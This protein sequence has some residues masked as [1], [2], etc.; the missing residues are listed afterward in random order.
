ME[1]IS[2]KRKRSSEEKARDRV[3]R[4][5]QA[6]QE[7]R[8][9][10]KRYVKELEETNQT[11]L[12]NN[13]L[14]VSTVS[15]LQEQNRLLSE[16]L[17]S[18]LSLLNQSPSPVLLPTLVDPVNTPFTPIVNS[19]SQKMET[20]ISPE[21]LFSFELSEKSP[22][23]TLDK[24][25]FDIK[26]SSTS[27]LTIEQLFN[28][29]QNDLYSQEQPLRDS[30]DPAVVKS[31][32]QIESPQ[33]L[34]STF[35]VGGGFSLYTKPTVYAFSNEKAQ[36]DM[37][38]ADT[39]IATYAW[40][41]GGQKDTTWKDKVTNGNGNGSITV[42]LWAKSVP[43][44]KRG[45]PGKNGFSSNYFAF[46]LYNNYALS[47]TTTGFNGSV[48]Q[49]CTSSNG[50]ILAP[51][52]ETI[53][54]D[55]NW[56]HYSATYDS[57]SGVKT[58][59][60][61]GEIY[62]TTNCTTSGGALNIDGGNLVLGNAMNSGSFE[63]WLDEVRIWSVARTQQQIKDNMH[64]ALIPSNEPD[65]VSY[66]PLDNPDPSKHVFFDKKGGFD[67]SLGVS[68]DASDTQSKYRER[69]API[70]DIS[71][72]PV[73][74]SFVGVKI[75]RGIPATFHL[76]GQNCKGSDIA[77]SATISSL[78]ATIPG[79][80]I[81]NDTVKLSVNSTVFLCDTLTI[82][83]ENSG[84]SKKDYYQGTFSIT[85]VQGV[86]SGYFQIEAAMVPKTAPGPSGNALYCNGNYDYLFAP[87]WNAAKLGINGKFTV[88]T[89]IYHLS[90][91]V[92]GVLFSFGNQEVSFQNSW[93]RGLSGNLNYANSYFCNGRYSIWVPNG[94]NPTLI[95][96]SNWDQ[97]SNNGSFTVDAFNK[98]GVWYHVAMVEDGD[99]LSL[100]IDGDLASKVPSFGG[101]NTNFS[102]IS[103]LW[104][105]HW[106]FWGENMHD[107]KGFI[108]EFRIYNT[109]I[110][111]EEIRDKMYRSIELPAQEPHLVTFYNFD[112]IYTV[113]GEGND[114]I[115]LTPDSSAFHNDIQ[116]SACVPNSP[117]FC[118]TAAGDNCN[119]VQFPSVPCYVTPGIQ[120]VLKTSN[121]QIVLS[122]APIGGYHSNKTF[123]TYSKD[124]NITITLYGAITTFDPS[125]FAIIDLTN[126]NSQIGV[127]RDSSGNKLVNGSHVAF[128]RVSSTTTVIFS[129]TY[130]QAGY[131][132]NQFSYAI[133]NGLYTSEYTEIS[134]D[135]Y[136]P[137]TQYFDTTLNVCSQCPHGTISLDSNLNS[138]CTPLSNPY[139]LVLQVIG[140]VCILV[141]ILILGGLFVTRNGKIVRKSDITLTTIII[142][143]CI[144]LHV[145]T[146]LKTFVANTVSCVLNPFILVQSLVLIVA[147]NLVK[148]YR[149]YDIFFV[150]CFHVGKETP[151][152]RIYAMIV[153]A[154]LI[155]VAIFAAWIK[156]A[157][158]TPVL[159]LS[160]TTHYIGCFSASHNSFNYDTIF[161]SVLSTYVFI[162]TFSSLYFC[163]SLK[164]TAPA[165]IDFS[166]T[167]RTIIQAIFVF[168]FIVLAQIYVGNPFT[169]D[170]IVGVVL[171]AFT[172]NVS[173]TTVGKIIYKQ[174]IEKS[175]GSKSDL[176]K[177]ANSFTSSILQSELENPVVYNG[178]EHSITDQVLQIRDGIQLVN[179]YIK[180]IGKGFSRWEISTVYIFPGPKMA[181]IRKYKKDET[182]TIHF[183]TRSTTKVDEPET[184]SDQD[185]F[186]IYSVIKEGR[187]GKVGEHGENEVG[188]MIRFKN[189]AERE[190]CLALFS[191]T[192]I[193]P[194]FSSQ[195]IGMKQ[196]PRNLIPFP[197]FTELSWDFSSI[198]NALKTIFNFA[199]MFI[200]KL[201]QRRIKARF[202]N[203]LIK[204]K[205]EVY[206]YGAFGKGSLSRGLP[207]YNKRDF[208]SLS[209][210]KKIDRLQIEQ[211]K[212]GNIKEDFLLMPEE[213]FF[214]SFGLGCLDLYSERKL[215]IQQ[216]WDL[217]C[218][219]D[220]KFP[221]RYAVYHHY[222]SLGYV[223]R[224]GILFG[225]DYVLY[226]Q[227]PQY[228][229]ADYCVWIVDQVVAKD[230][231]EKN[232]V[233]N[234]AKKKLVLVRVQVGGNLKV[235]TCLA[236]FVISDGLV[237]RE[238]FTLNKGAFHLPK[239]IQ[240]LFL[241][242]LIL[243]LDNE[244]RF[245]LMSS[246]RVTDITIHLF[247]N[248]PVQTDLILK[249]FTNATDYC[250]QL[251]EF[252]L[253]KSVQ[254][255]IPQITDAIMQDNSLHSNLK[256]LDVLVSSILE[257]KLFTE[258]TEISSPIKF[259]LNHGITNNK[260]LAVF[261]RNRKFVQLMELY[262]LEWLT[263]AETLSSP[264]FIEQVLKFSLSE[265]IIEDEIFCKYVY[266]FLKLGNLTKL[267]TMLT[268]QQLMEK[269]TDDNVGLIFSIGV[270]TNYPEL[271]EIIIADSEKWN[272]VCLNDR[273]YITESI[274]YCIHYCNKNLEAILENFALT[275]AE[276]LEYLE[277]LINQEHFGDSESYTQMYKMFL[278]SKQIKHFMKKNPTKTKQLNIPQVL[279]ENA[280]NLRLTGAH[281][282]SNRV[283]ILKSTELEE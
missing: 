2:R 94:L 129:P 106:P 132:A 26:E 173:T 241:G 199:K 136:C 263:H 61:D 236:K 22:V 179:V 120:S 267:K 73:Q 240:D 256:S 255:Q 195:E 205:H 230:L 30:S 10:Q 207:T 131:G 216:Q 111:Q 42:E 35:G 63:G 102:D 80:T 246:K 101:Y 52:L 37:L 64:V 103:G 239:D 188:I 90:N 133:T 82:L 87:T 75:Y 28:F 97:P 32:K 3:I 121:P 203:G 169:S 66:L 189:S 222:R 262:W 148:H 160:D 24:L 92:E 154:L 198:Y 164:D 70:V 206:N 134:I 123:L 15:T 114:T 48:P 16:K 41:H 95:G 213:C 280:M 168:A 58:V 6:A 249:C 122:S 257:S 161:E 65:L 137:P 143:G 43:Y 146:I 197:F 110:S 211:I 91:N 116:F 184:R 27:D 141:E 4:N 60:L 74:A 243:R 234:Q 85:G 266:S 172:V 186:M 11:L 125:L 158:P 190:R 145:Y 281:G 59:Y 264:S 83:S 225:T 54:Y 219:L 258:I 271:L 231:V 151:I 270:K 174:L 71:D 221:I 272:F 93:C 252:I 187:A 277:C 229:H 29:D 13:A 210:K 78:D 273:G 244:T 227:G 81:W 217:F 180:I 275:R 140:G 105:C 45:N 185:K 269:I 40:Y 20:P 265:K 268:P 228:R 107:F 109:S 76:G 124:Q 139:A 72:A 39:D 55:D 166:G 224:S 77:Q 152:Y 117:P 149:L 23:N 237:N 56:H 38:Q 33:S 248:N 112:T 51:N 17:D 247:K 49:I 8:D 67:I 79:I 223:V 7:S 86:S 226:S 57:G 153:I 19:P 238:T 214:L 98:Y 276:I 69:L 68:F 193:K 181:F 170:I 245:Q 50:D 196:N 150:N 115:T 242:Y 144:F 235:P 209:E 194:T 233:C 253:A 104:L 200:S 278:D 44:E 212:K 100:Y 254:Y 53:F 113:K 261:F 283:D 36:N 9:R 25:E 84:L 99:N 191:G 279:H 34:T 175:S 159:M 157:P 18:I 171:N 5:R 282:N 142:V 31:Q 21:S 138:S 163:Y 259:C 126:F 1:E 202:I 147:T 251:L 96:Y 176:A 130:P 46:G 89:W 260:D 182:I 218:K 47:L 215:S 155:P 204:T 178:D 232:R 127:L 177:N 162:I 128:S 62:H 88:S 119:A 118:L 192:K 208:E 250:P 165:Y 274:L 167:L 14:L 201:F 183:N 135:I 12:K 220:D 108:D 156:S